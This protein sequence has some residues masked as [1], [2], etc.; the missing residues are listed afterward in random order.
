MSENF[1]TQVP[2]IGSHTHFSNASI[3]G[4]PDLHVHDTFE[5]RRRNIQD[6][7]KYQLFTTKS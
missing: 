7:L 2:F 4:F 5:D 6:T 3:E 1:Y